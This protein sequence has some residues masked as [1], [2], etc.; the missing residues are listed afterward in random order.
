[1]SVSILPGKQ[2]DAAT[3]AVTTKGF[4]VGYRIKSGIPLMSRGISS[5]GCVCIKVN[6]G[7]FRFQ[8]EAV[9]CPEC[10]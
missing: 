7:S 2:Q 6:A 1:M 4:C 5:N 3:V 8:Q 10:N 9:T